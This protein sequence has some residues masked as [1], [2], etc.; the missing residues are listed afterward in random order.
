MVGVV[1][2]DHGD[3]LSGRSVAP[4]EIPSVSIQCIRKTRPCL[5][6]LVPGILTNRRE[7]RTR[8][9]CREEGEEV[10]DIHSVISGDIA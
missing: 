5:S 1:V 8:T 2:L 9:P 6:G 10:G 4:N 7:L 3:A